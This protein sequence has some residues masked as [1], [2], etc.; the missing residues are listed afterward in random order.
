MTDEGRTQS[1]YVTVKVPR[2]IYDDVARVAEKNRRSVM[3]EV[4]FVLEQHVE[5]NRHLI[6]GEAAR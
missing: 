3:G 5:A 6:A 2:A 1:P 4:A